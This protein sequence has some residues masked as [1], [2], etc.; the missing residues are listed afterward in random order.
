MER[1]LWNAIVA[2]LAA[3][4]KPRTPRSFTYRDELIVE[5]W[6]WSVIHDRPM[7]WACEGRNWPLDLRRRPRP[8]YSHLT[9][10]LR[11]PSVRALLTAVEEQAAAD[12]RLLEGPPGGLRPGR[13]R[14]GQ[15][16]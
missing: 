6:Y 11:T 16:V 3:V 9:R 10:R 14:Q 15:R 1:Q 12:R 5:V 13:R 2:V 8:S 7:S 4:D